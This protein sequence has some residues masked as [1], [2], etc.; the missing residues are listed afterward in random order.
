ME[1]LNDDA[2]WI[3]LMGFII[4]TGIFF[5]AIIL[6]QS[7]LVGQTT[8]EGVLEFP[9][10]EIMDIRSEIIDIAA[11]SDPQFLKERK[12][13][14]ISVLAMERE[15]AVLSSSIPQNTTFRDGFYNYTRIEI[16]YNNGVT[17]YDEEYLLAEKN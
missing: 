5:L 13:K 6:N 4:S 12:Q 14:T 2:Q 8:S 11:A 1:R 7:V 17:S 16:H 15:N 9:K 10:S 3:V